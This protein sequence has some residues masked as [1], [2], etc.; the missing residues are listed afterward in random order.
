MN[1]P[2]LVC[3]ATLFLFCELIGN[4]RTRAADLYREPF[5]PQYHFT[6]ATNWMNDPNGMVFYDGEYHLFYQY[7]PF[8]DKWG[9]M[10]WGHAVSRDL[11]H[12]EHLP[13]ALYEENDVM[14]FSGSVV[15]DW[16]NTSG[17]GRDGK[18][19]LVAI[20]TGHYTQ[21]PLQNQHLAYSN[22][23]GRTWTKFSGNPVLDIGEKDFRDPKVFW[24]EP[25][26]RWV[27]VVSWPVQRKVRFYSSPNLKEWTHLSDFGPAGSTTG[28]WECPDMFPLAVETGRVKV[29]PA[30]EGSQAPTSSIPA[31]A[32]ESGRD[33]QEKWVLIVN[34]GSGAPAGGSGCQYFVGNFDGQQFTL[35]SSFPQPQPEFVPEGKVIADFE[36]D[37]FGSWR[38]SGGAFGTG[39]ARGK[40]GGQQA[41]DGF[42]GRGL[43][44]TFLEGDRSE[45][46]LIS[47]PFDVTQPYLSFLIGGGNH[48]GKTCLNLRVDGRVVRTATGDNA[49]HVVWKSWDVRE[50]IGKNASLEIVD[51]ETGGWG[52]VNVDHILLADA[53]ARPPTAPGLW[54]DWG[55]DFYAAV[56]WSDVPKRDGRRLWLGWMSNW[57][58]ANDVPTA[59]WRSAMSLPRELRL[60]QVEDGLRLVQKPV[61]EVE[62]LR[63]KREQIR[64]RNLTQRVSL[65][66]LRDATSDLFELEAEFEPTTNAVFALTLRSGASDETVL[67]V[68]VPNRELALDRTRS[69]KVGFHA[70]FPG[71]DTAPLRL[72][73]GRVKLRLFVDTSSIEV[74]ANNGETV[75]SNLILSS[76][77][78]RQLEL[79]VTQGEI[80]QASLSVWKLKSA[81]AKER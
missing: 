47:P 77:G 64:L 13:V 16:N 32:A 44:N 37:D 70:Q 19:P 69:G 59:P 5:R 45:G 4:Y 81:W 48:A 39:P 40:I 20:Y 49:E 3:L 57:E 55:R 58:Y 25:T 73:D 54:A 29:M 56:S 72:V 11:I 75:L 9:H 52:H 66:K 51:R 68:D 34:V 62:K 65:S 31:E 28:I 23:R 74:F 1:A 18:P 30:G 61:T 8:G 53:P 50:F 10:S 80:Q 2:G 38:A 12:W 79:A 35:D 7:N 24:H 33:S 14:I 71:I 6:P 42:R 22:D 63:M 46:T 41:V 78:D 17:F 36:G 15:V 67:R 21:K 27:M 60:R 43:V 26:Q 76:T